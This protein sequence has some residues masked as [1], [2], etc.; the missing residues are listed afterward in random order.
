MK[1]TYIMILSVVIIISLVSGCQESAV[2]KNMNEMPA[3]ELGASTQGEIT[4]QIT[5]MNKYADIK[6]I[7]GPTGKAGYINRDGTYYVRLLE[8]FSIA[9]E[10]DIHVYVSEKKNLKN[11]DDMKEDAYEV[12]ILTAKEGNQEYR[13]AEFVPVENINSV[14]LYNKEENILL[15][16]A[17]FE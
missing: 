8:G 4:L 7:N 10:G 3:E 2:E 14:A 9:D 11:A 12:S 16:W 13:V 15:A 6:G 1:T 17:V 5:N